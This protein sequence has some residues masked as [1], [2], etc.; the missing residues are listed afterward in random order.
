V[1]NEP[2]K[3]KPKKQEPKIQESEEQ[4]PKEQELEEQVRRPSTMPP[5]T[6]VKTTSED[7]GPPPLAQSASFPL[8]VTYATPTTSTP[9]LSLVKIPRK[10][11]I[12]GPEH[13]LQV[14]EQLLYEHEFRGK[15]Y[16][17]AHL[18][19]L[20]HGVFA[21]F[22][23]H[24]KTA[25]HVTF[26]AITFVFHPSISVRHRFEAATIEITARTEDHEP[27]RFV[28]FAPH[29]AYG[30]IS[31]E[32]LKWNFQLGATLGI[33]KGPAVLS[34]APKIERETDK[35]INTMMKIQGSTR[36]WRDPEHHNHKMFPDSL[37]VWTLEE[38]EQQ[39]TGL[40]RE[41]TFI[42]LVERPATHQHTENAPGFQQQRQQE[43]QM[44]DF[45]G[46]NGVS[47]GTV[48]EI[49]RLSHDAVFKPMRL[50]IH[51][52]PRISNELSL[53]NRV[54]RFKSGCPSL[55]R[56]LGVTEPDG[57]LLTRQVGQ[58]LPVQ[59]S[60]DDTFRDSHTLLDGYYNFAKM[61]GQFEDLIEL[62][63]NAMSSV[64]RAL[65]KCFCGKDTDT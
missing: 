41:F 5:R 53:P 25:M 50:S 65:P 64:V 42:F 2:K 34:V 28:K 44:N 39:A 21:D 15:C 17:S 11:N 31:T 14:T 38:N 8:G 7:I 24:G 56:A 52:E 57:P 3:H 35:V 43:Q 58:R 9:L 36:S 46:S 60:Y 62:P 26:V 22:N 1:V 13:K 18:Q 12:D 59:H 27:L 49:K 55:I 20:Q 32:T 6:S 45:A 54:Y 51:V 4:G 16:V 19:R 23:L 33:T 40:P 37:L 48:E 10:P 63:G 29:V 30:R 61:P 47:N